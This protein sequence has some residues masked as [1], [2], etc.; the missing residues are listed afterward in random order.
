MSFALRKS[1]AHGVKMQKNSCWA[2]HVP[3]ARTLLDFAFVPGPELRS[4]W[5]HRGMLNVVSTNL[6]VF[7]DFELHKVLADF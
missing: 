1:R 5:H 3:V 7:T 4:L 6:N 2:Y